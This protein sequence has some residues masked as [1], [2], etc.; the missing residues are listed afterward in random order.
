MKR[1]NLF[2]ARGYLWGFLWKY[3][4]CSKHFILFVLCF[5]LFN[6][7][8]PLIYCFDFLFKILVIFNFCK[9][10]AILKF[11][12]HSTS[13]INCI[14][15]VL[16]VISDILTLELVFYLFKIGMTHL[17]Y[18]LFNKNGGSSN[19]KSHFRWTLCDNSSRL[20]DSNCC[21]KELSDWWGKV[22]RSVFWKI[23]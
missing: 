22:H 1:K 2:Q 23:Y 18:H 19:L 14:L 5:F 6:S 9:K 21:C 13:F 16:L 8:A 17:I 7:N 15:K 4:V 20:S 3:F 10:K 12:I 11:D